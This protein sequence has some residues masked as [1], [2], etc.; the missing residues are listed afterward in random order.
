[1]L[2][3][4]EEC[5][6]EAS[7]RNKEAW[8]RRSLVRDML[9]DSIIS[10]IQ[11]DVCICSRSSAQQEETQPLKSCLRKPKEEP[12]QLKKKSKKSGNKKRKRSYS[13]GACCGQERIYP[14][15]APHLPV[16]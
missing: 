14:L 11:H 12:V 16:H 1:M 8:E 10:E 6:E 15:M 2:P 7:R 9:D 5:Y 4:R 3:T 13:K